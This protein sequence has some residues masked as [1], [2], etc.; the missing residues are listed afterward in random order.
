MVDW[1]EDNYAKVLAALTI[2]VFWIVPM[3]LYSL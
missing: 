2:V 1:I 3:V